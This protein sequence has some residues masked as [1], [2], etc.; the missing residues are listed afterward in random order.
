MTTKQAHTYSNKNVASVFRK[1]VKAVRVDPF[2]HILTAAELAEI[3]DRINAGASP[4]M[5]LVRK[6]LRLC[7]ERLDIIN[8]LQ[9]KAGP[10]P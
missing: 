4:R 5:F 10:R 3:E 1:H 8:H 6:M 7:A 2:P 9:W